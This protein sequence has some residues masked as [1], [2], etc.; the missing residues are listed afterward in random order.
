MRFFTLFVFALFLMNGASAQIS[1]D[2]AGYNGS[3]YAAN[4][5]PIAVLPDGRLNSQVFTLSNN[6]SSPMSLG[7]SDAGR[8]S[9]TGGVSTGGTYAFNLG[10]GNMALGI[11]PAGSDY[12]PGYIQ[13]NAL[14]TSGALVT[15]LQISYDI[16]V[17]NDQ[18]RSNSFNFSYSTDGVNFTD[19]SS[20]N[21]STPLSADG[22]P[23]YETIGRSTMIT[24]LSI[25]DMS[26]FFIRWTTDDNGG[27][28]S[29]DEIGLDNIM[30]DML[31][32][33]P[34]TLAEFKVTKIN[35][36]AELSWTTA[37]ESGNDFFA[38]ERST[39][40]RVFNEIDRVA[41]AGDSQVSLD[42]KSIDARPL[43]GVSYYRLRQVDLDGTTAFYGPIAFRNDNNGGKPAIFPN[44]VSKEIN[45]SNAPADISQM[46]V[47]NLNGQSVMAFDAETKSTSQ[48]NVSQLPAGIYFLRYF[49][50]GTWNQ[51]R[52]VKK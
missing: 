7:D 5:N 46:S 44:P 30:V 52:F 34:I 12:T 47:V 16:I 3:G 25:P 9:T 32:P 10:G 17:Y 41:G 39:D 24:G 50:E 49:A 2:F 48:L 13:L 37:S 33:F 38:I 36:T 51:I 23:Q 1:I 40:G 29:R 20:L 45:L 42:Y 21:Y 15:E 35:K 6:G 14:N 27:G 8:G 43:A 28:G 18:S 4:A 11:Q 19:V 31:M 22:S 26:P